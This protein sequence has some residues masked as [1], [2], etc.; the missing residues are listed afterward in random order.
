ME[1][2]IR[3]AGMCASEDF[4]PCC[5][6]YLDLCAVVSSAEKNGFDGSGPVRIVTFDDG[7][8]H[9]ART[10]AIDRPV[11]D[12]VTYSRI[13]A[14]LSPGYL[15][16]RLLPIVR[17]LLPGIVVLPVMLL[18]GEHPI[19]LNPDQPIETRVEDLLG[20]M[21][22]EE[23]I[24]QVHGD[25]K[26]STAA[27]PRLEIPRRWLSDGPHGVREDVGP[28]TWNAAGHTDDFAT[29]M[30]AL[31]AL[32]ST[33][34]S[35]LA[36]AYGEVIG[37]ESRARGKDIMLGPIAD[38]P[39]TPLSGR[40]YEYI[41]EDPYLVAR[42]SANYVRGVQSHEVAA[43]IKHFAANN[44]EVG[45]A[46]IN[47]DMDERTLR[48]I[49]LPPFE[50]AVREAGVW[51]VMGAYSRFR[52]EHCAYN[53]Y[54]INKILKGEWGFQGLVMSDWSG[55]HSTPDA[56]FGGLDLEM[57]TEVPG[58]EDARSYN[59]YYL[60]R[61]FL[62]GIRNG[63]YPVSTLDD[64]V[65]RNLRVMF[66]THVFDIRER[67]ALNTPEHQAM[68]RRVAEEGMVLL[69]N[70][71]D[72][73]P[74]DPSRLTSLAVI[75][76]NAVRRNAA[77]FFGAGVK[78]MYEIT[79]LEG[80]VQRV[81]SNVNVTY[82]TGY[83]KQGG[84]SNLVE[85][86][87]TAARQADAAI[88]VAGFNHSRYLDDEGWDRNDLELP[89]GQNELIQRVLE[90]NPRTIVV[91][92]SGPAIDPG[93]WLAQAPAVLQ[94]NYSGME[95]GRA[96]ARVLFGDVNPSGKLACTYPKRLMDSPPHAL[97]TYPGT[98]G[99]LFYKE[100]LLVGYRWFDTKEIEPL[101]PFG[102]GLSYTRFAYSGLKLIPGTN[103]QGLAVTAEFEI[104]NSGGR[105]GAEVAQLYVHQAQPGLPRPV[106]ELK[107][108]Q[109]VM[110]KPGERRR[111]SIPLDQRAF[112]YYDPAKKGWVAEA[113]E[114]KIL[115]GS[116]SR[117]IR[118]QDDFH[119]STTTVE[120]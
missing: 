91:L 25:S 20:R 21:T 96:L 15:L 41:G 45:R 107:G 7:A 119:L 16:R 70:N 35:E 62:E 49:Y 31:S 75:G 101:F 66:A 78:A 82:S 50:A 9:V 59:D 63:Q 24:S 32:G 33:W 11:R 115:V 18:A 43:C 58:L 17:V 98:N 2:K 5:F 12:L 71:A 10:F 83:S 76:E 110:L 26:F 80:I 77:G 64:K 89:Y 111:V 116:S 95:G 6:P 51:A 38:I 120:K 114:F 109:K 112:A 99:T 61:P 39:R 37:E 118:L 108:F 30:P 1:K 40:I 105:A 103:S 19:Y 67:G 23:K 48:E 69:K 97:D 117:D 84:G 106:K 113:G 34:N 56:V 53:D 54:L 102:Y 90:A 92:I 68:A 22:L 87:V 57:G 14:M 72:T 52:G 36:F 88:V 27:I 65:R 29:A 8:E 46:T 4:V 81:G 55:T 93:P 100:G 86:A 85:R 47:M 94:A 3:N 60:A 104:T 42:L 79:P 73:L 28:H 44:Q 74:L 13:C